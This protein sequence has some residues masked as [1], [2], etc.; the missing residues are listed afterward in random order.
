VHAA[1]RAIAMKAHPDRRA[2]ANEQETAAANERFRR[3]RE[4]YVALRST[5]SKRDRRASD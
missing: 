5:M 1:F 2:A 4:A 3:V